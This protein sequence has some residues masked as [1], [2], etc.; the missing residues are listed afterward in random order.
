M[1]NY[2]KMRLP[3][4]IWWLVFEAV[5][6]FVFF[7]YDLTLIPFLHLTLLFAF[8]IVIAGIIDFLAKNRKHRLL[9]NKHVDMVEP[10][11]Y[12][13]K[14]YREIIEELEM[15]NRQIRDKANSDYNDML[16][17]FTVWAH[18]IKTPIAAL[19][20]TVQNIEDDSLRQMLQ[21]ELIRT[22]EYADMVMNY[23][24]LRDDSSDY[25]FENTDL[26]SVVRQE[27]RRMR[28]LFISKKISV[29]FEPCEAYAVTDRRWLEF[30]LGQVLT[31][32]I[33]Y[34]NGGTITISVSPKSITVKD[35]GIGISEEDLPRIFEKGYTGYNGRSDKKS[36]GIG[37]YLVKR[38]MVAIGGD[39]EIRSAQGEGTTAELIIKR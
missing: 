32:S 33:K 9:T 17:Y 25:V 19:S 21:S 7:L 37:L 14:D 31:N 30:A 5:M 28:T 8:A 34:S 38:A 39:I 12:I 3:F 2:L 23:L 6:F 11:D 26:T 1:A 16:D 4:I 35:E 15:L 36:T 29:S 13:E 20:L 24:R 22:E 10:Q 27:I 18:Q